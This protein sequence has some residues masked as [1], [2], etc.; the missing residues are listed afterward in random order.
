MKLLLAPLLLLAAVPALAQL[1]Q[2][3]VA[4]NGTLLNISASAEATRIPDVARISAGVVT[5]ATD[6]NSALRANAQQMDK[7]MAA[8]KKSGIAERDVQTSGVSLNPQYKYED[9]KAPQIVGYQASNTV[10]IKV[11]N[12]SKLGAVLDGLA[13][14]GANQINGPMF[15]IDQPEPVYDQAR[16][17]AL[18]KAQERAQT[19]AK[20]LNLR[21]VRIVSIDETN[22]GG[23]QPMAVLSAAPRA[24][25]E[26]NSPISP[27]ETTLSVTLNVVFE[28]GR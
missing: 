23:F 10:N 26:F 16:M 4:A 1:S 5:Q 7:V 21:V 3:A 28:L 20:N 6:S 12:I 8:I 19:Y 27:G 22:N 25:K 11:R 17:D 2:P 15:S 14:Q 18:K 13:D 9:N 24:A